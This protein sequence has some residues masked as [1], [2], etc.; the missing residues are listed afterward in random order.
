MALAP[1]PLRLEDKWVSDSKPSAL[2]KEH[3]LLK[4]QDALQH[5]PANHNAEAGRDEDGKVNQEELLNYVVGAVN[6]LT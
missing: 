5:Y 3:L 2:P 4:L 6:I 1:P